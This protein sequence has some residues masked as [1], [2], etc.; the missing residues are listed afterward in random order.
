VGHHEQLSIVIRHF[1]KQTNRPI[2]T[3]V[4]LRRMKSV[5]A[6]S[7]FDAI[8]SILLQLSKNW[9]SVISVF[10]DGAS[11]MSGGIGGVQAKYICPHI[12]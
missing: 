3:F 8:T 1:D 11:T 4:A 2:E 9:T 7:I 6:Q 12:E 10:F 5:D